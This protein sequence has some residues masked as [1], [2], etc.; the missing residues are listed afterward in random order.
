MLVQRPDWQRLD[1]HFSGITWRMVRRVA[2]FSGRWR[3]NTTSCISARQAVL[4]LVAANAVLSWM[5]FVLKYSHKISCCM[6]LICMKVS[7]QVKCYL[8]G[9]VTL[10]KTC[11]SIFYSEFFNYQRHFRSLSGLIDV[12]SWCKNRACLKVFIDTWN[13]SQQ[14][15]CGRWLMTD[16][17]GC[18]GFI[19]Y[20]TQAGALFFNQPCC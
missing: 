12:Y 10:N 11:E 17:L 5:W 7:A 6:D 3:M 14:K 4:F 19:L 20:S 15:P 1:S 18:S 16:I 13:A 8:K 9:N 2:P